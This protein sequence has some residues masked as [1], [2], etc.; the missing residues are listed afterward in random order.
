MFE[1]NGASEYFKSVDQLIIDAHYIIDLY[2]K[3]NKEIT[4]I[5]LIWCLYTVEA[6]Y[7]AMNDKKELYPQIKWK[8]WASLGCHEIHQ[9]F[10]KFGRYDI[11]L[12][13][14]YLGDRINKK[15]KAV[16]DML[17]E[18]IFKSFIP[19]QLRNLLYETKDS[20]WKAAHKS[21]SSVL[22]ETEI[23]KKLMK[24]WATQ[25]LNIKPKLKTKNILSIVLK[26]IFKI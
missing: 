9:H 10:G 8:G 26:I 25:F 22:Y 20:P 17:F 21:S 24:E 11:S 4:Y 5:E 3:N 14:E 16:I 7:C 15:H 12:S 18:N 6:F 23:N 2:H 19:A 1:D 13:Y